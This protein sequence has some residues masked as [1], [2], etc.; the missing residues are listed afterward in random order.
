MK[1]TSKKNA[2]QVLIV[3]VSRQKVVSLKV[4]GSL[5]SCNHLCLLEVWHICI[6]C[7]NRLPMYKMS[8]C[9]QLKST[10]QAFGLA[11]QR[12]GDHKLDS[13]RIPSPLGK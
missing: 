11:K 6:L 3:V 13:G 2:N 10:S 7:V 9:K 4:K 5:Y 8:F 12:D 1:Y